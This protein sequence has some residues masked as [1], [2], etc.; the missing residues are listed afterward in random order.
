M[1]PDQPYPAPKVSSKRPPVENRCSNCHALVGKGR[2]HRCTKV[3]AQDNL[4]KLVKNKSLKSKEKIG[5]KVIKGIFDDKNVTRRG[6]T[7]MLA[8]GGSSKLPVSLSIK[9][10]KVR[11][12]HEN[13]RKLQVVMGQSDRG[14]K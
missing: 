8:T 9:M 2:T 10:N 6:G 7:V 5:A 4:H 13:L 11:F 12:S 3:G 1:F 14:I